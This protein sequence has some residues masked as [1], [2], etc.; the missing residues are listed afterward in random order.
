MK[1]ISNLGSLLAVARPVSVASSIASS[2]LEGRLEVS[3]RSSL[4][5]AIVSLG[6]VR[7]HSSGLGS[8]GG[9]L[10]GSGHGIAWQSQI[11]AQVLDALVG[12]VPVVVIPVEGLTHEP[13]GSKTTEDANYLKVGHIKSIRVLCLVVVLLGHQNALLEKV[14]V[15]NKS[16]LL[17]DKLQG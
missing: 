16:V 5:L 13:L 8:H 14:G 15:D 11:C 10:E 9:G 1:N 17:G 4:T 12:Q 3:S 7:S 2:P 6:T